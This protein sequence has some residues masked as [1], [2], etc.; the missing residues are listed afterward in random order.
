V[1]L[2]VDQSIELGKLAEAVACAEQDTTPEALSPDDRQPVY[3]SLYQ[4]HVPKLADAGVVEYDD[5]TGLVAPTD[6]LAE[7]TEHFEGYDAEST[8]LSWLDYHVVGCSISV[9]L[10]TVHFLS[11]VSGYALL[12]YGLSVSAPTGVTLAH[13]SSRVNAALSSGNG[14]A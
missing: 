11:I 9:A 8:S 3:V 1:L 6:A 7:L 14:G 4:T 13:L 10:W 5:E 12:L 2:D